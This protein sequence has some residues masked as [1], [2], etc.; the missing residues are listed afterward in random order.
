MGKRLMILAVTVILGL[1]GSI[2]ADAADPDLVGWW[3]LDGD[4]SDSS[5]NGHNGTP[6]GNARFDVGYRGQCLV[7]DGVGDYF[8]VDGY[9]GLMSDNPVTVTAWVQ[10]TGNGTMVYWG[11]HS[12][13]RRVDFRINAGRLRVEHGGGNLQGDTV[14]NDGSWHHVALTIETNAVVGYPE[15]KLYLDGQDDSRNTRDAEEDRFQLIEH[16][17]NVDLT[18]GRRTPNDD[19]YFPGL[20]DDVRLYSRVL[21]Q[22]EILDLIKLGYLGTARNPSPA[23]GSLFEQHWTTLK[24]DAGEA[25]V[26]HNLYLGTNFD[27]VNTAAPETFVGNLTDTAQIV[28]FP[29]FPAPEGLVPGTM[30]FWR[31]DEI[32]DQHPDSPWRGP[33]WSFRVPPTT[34]YNPAPADGEPFEFLDVD[35]AWAPGLKAVMSAVYFGTDANV[36]ASDTGAAPLLDTTF[37]PGELAM[38]TTYRWR[39]DTFNGA[40]WVKGPVWSFTTLPEIPLTADPSLVAWWTFDEGAGN[41]A[42]DWSGHGH[43][44]DFTGA[45]QWVEG[46]DGGALLFSGSGQYLEAFGYPGVLGTQDRTV[47]AWIQTTELG[48]IMAWGLQTSTQKW[49]FRVQDN[50]GNPGTIRVE[51][52]G[53][54]IC[55]WTDVRDG[56]WH[57][58]AAVLESDGLPTVLDI[59][60][61]LDGWQEAI[62]DFQ[63]VD[64]NTFSGERNVRIGDGHQGRPFQG[65]ID[66]V[67][68]YDRALSEEE[69]NLIMR[70]DPLRAWKPQPIHPRIVDIRTATPLTW[71]AGDNASRHDVY[72][73]VNEAAVAAATT[74]TPGVYRGR[75]SAATY[76]PPE[77]MEWGQTYFWR[78]DEINADGSVTIGQVW[79]FTVA[80]YLIV[81]DF[82]SYTDEDE[83]LGKRIYQTWIDGWVNGNGA[84]VGNWDPPFAERT[85]VHGGMQAMPMDYNNVNSPWYSEAERTWE[86]PQDWTFGDANTLV[87]YFRGQAPSFLQ[88][89]DTITLSAAG[90][91]IWHD[92]ALTRFDECRFVYKRLNG[93]GSIIARVDSLVDTHAWA[94][95]GVMIRETFAWGSRHASV[96]VTPG[97]GVAFQRRLADNDVG[98]STAEG[99]I[100]A[101]HWVKLTRNGNTLTAQHSADGVTWVD[102]THATNPTSD[103]VIMSSSIYIGLALTSHS[104]GNPTTAVFSGIQT[105]GSVSGSWQVA[106]IGVTHPVNSPES[107]YLAV[108]D[109]AGQAATVSH[110]DPAATTLTDWQTWAIGLATIRDAGVKVHQVKKLRIGVGDRDHAQPDGAG[111]LYID[112]I[113][114]TKGVPVEPNDP[115]A[116]P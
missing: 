109:G 27:D 90:W 58:V 71:E 72:F 101:P 53:G 41:N 95:G 108:E 80:D 48:D 7:L 93:D 37:D 116:V 10:T 110:P 98:L 52:Q 69:L 23:D 8:T 105:T 87:V 46:Y 9:K 115:N 70:I 51:C 35:L 19:R 40:E 112:D 28:G 96:F 21:G 102:V 77:D 63:L 114:V 20:I 49:N 73:D 74:E 6:A 22:T 104:A 61:Y 66:D 25:A 3:K 94:K 111:R 36:V 18:I 4:G 38:G 56:E 16:A 79:Q 88:T 106:D 113:R 33:V 39:V 34:A 83:A 62:S 14:L 65:L 103:T 26:S 30:Y 43:H 42:L 84:T 75:L 11:R 44:A 2:P 100:V 82:E 81:D 68:I 99:G 86:K 55:G 89:A 31:V 57:H 85:I 1:V 15:V 12:G 17:D 59:R 47:A 76:D 64:V 107:V 78:V 54:R 97:N 24:W 45:A 91:D 67:R 5:G 32:N 92:S 60:L 29:T 13:R 50:N